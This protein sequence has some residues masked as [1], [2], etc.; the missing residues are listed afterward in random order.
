MNSLR[1]L[2]RWDR[3][4]ESHIKHLCLCV[5][6]LCVY[7]VLSVGSGLGDGLITRPRSPTICVK[8]IT[9]LKKREREI[10]LDRTRV[11]EPLNERIRDYT[12]S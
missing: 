2:E 9:K 4:F 7:V 6:L 12:V 3:G 5:R 11:V 1:S 10:G 8:M